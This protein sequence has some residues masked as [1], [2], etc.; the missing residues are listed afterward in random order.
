MRV[1]LSTR[2][3]ILARTTK[4]PHAPNMGVVESGRNEKSSERRCRIG[5]HLLI[6]EGV[7]GVLVVQGLA[8]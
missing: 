5:G 4:Y 2:E 1:A 8:R 6:G 7:D 3:R